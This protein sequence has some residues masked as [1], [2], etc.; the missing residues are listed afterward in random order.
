MSFNKNVDNHF[1]L[2]LFYHL[3][4]NEDR[5]YRGYSLVK[6]RRNI[7]SHWMEN[8]LS[9]CLS[10]AV[11][12]KYC[13][14]VTCLDCLEITSHWSLSQVLCSMLYPTVL[15]LVLLHNKQTMIVLP[16]RSVARAGDVD[17]DE[18]DEEKEVDLGTESSLAVNSQH[19]PCNPSRLRPGFLFVPLWKV[20]EL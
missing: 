6:K 18:E 7:I 9:F 19:R 1:L 17:E 14:S 13:I 8:Q 16:L 2:V 3:L 15:P 11:S 4:E 10:F 5:G 20:F 12:S